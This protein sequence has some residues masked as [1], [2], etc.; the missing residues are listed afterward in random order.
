MLR[1]LGLLTFL[2]LVVLVIGWFSGWFTVSVEGGERPGVGIG[3]DKREVERDIDDLRGDVEDA[4]TT[5]ADRLEG[6]LLAADVA[7]RV[8]ELATGDED[9]VRLPVTR[10]ALVLLDGEPASLVV[11]RRGDEV[12]VQLDDQRR[13]RRIVA[14]RTGG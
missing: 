8:I 10:D 3:V 1:F 2:A 12:E 6:R 7:G 9:K 14:R 13:V 11:L 5:D 4:V